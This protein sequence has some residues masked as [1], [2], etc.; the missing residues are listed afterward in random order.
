M[1]Q[2]IFH[3]AMSI[4]VPISESKA[5]W[6]EYWNQAGQTWAEKWTRTLDHLEQ[7]DRDDRMNA[8]GGAL[9]VGC[10]VAPGKANEL[11]P[12]QREVYFRAREIA[13]AIPG[14][15]RYYEEQIE[16]KRA[17]VL[18]NS[19]KDWREL[20]AIQDAGGTY[21]T[22]AGYINYS[23]TAFRILGHLPS[24]ETVAVL[25]RYLN[26]PEGRDGKTLLG[27]PTD[28]DD[29]E[30][31]PNAAQAAAAIRKLG[32]EHPPFRDEKT[33]ESYGAA[34]EEI[35]AWRDWW[36]EVKAGKRSYR[37]AGDPTEYGPEG[38]VSAAK[39]KSI[40]L[41]QRRDRE[42]SSGGRPTAVDASEPGAGNSHTGTVI[43]LLSV[44][45]LVAAVAY[46]FLRR[47]HGSEA[48]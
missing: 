1:K 9:R 35:D 29:C 34:T 27:F 15:A 25:G 28:R 19:K 31:T 21:E 24:A 18:A 20:N 39:L 10:N 42:R 16:K 32:I 45:A 40:E 17:E 22:E 23:E 4:I 36:N 11:R 12:E 3:V 48:G 7:F 44:A 14:H 46:K 43:I 47:R 30:V 37:F 26:D 13:L 6:H 41:N 33:L 8:L 38:P 5:D 2:L